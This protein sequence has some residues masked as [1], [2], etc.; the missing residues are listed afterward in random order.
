MSLTRKTMSGRSRRRL[1]RRHLLATLLAVVAMSLLSPFDATALNLDQKG[2]IASSPLSPFSSWYYAV[3]DTRS[4]QTAEYFGW[5]GI[6]GNIYWKT[7]GILN[8]Y[9]P[10]HDLACGAIKIDSDSWVQGGLWHDLDDGKRLYV[11]AYRDGVSVRS[12]WGAT[13]GTPSNVSFQISP[14]GYV[15]PSGMYEWRVRVAGTVWYAYQWNDNGKATAQVE[16]QQEY[17]EGGV[18]KLPLV[19][20]GTNRASYSSTS[21]ALYLLNGTGAWELWDT[22]L[23]AGTTWAHEYLPFAHYSA[24]YPYY[25]F[26]GHKP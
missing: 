22:S 23:R 16:L 6:K 14:T 4:S 15:T 26:A 24:G 19:Y 5:R 2:Y 20:M 1:G 7:D 17:P 25:Y 21:E 8:R 18:S 11:E 13:V 9:A 10:T 3:Q 12:A